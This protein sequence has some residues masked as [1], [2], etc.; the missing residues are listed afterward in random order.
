LQL[1][2][3]KAGALAGATALSLLGVAIGESGSAAASSSIDYSTCN[4][5]AACGGM[6]A[7]VKAA[8]AEGQLNTI[9]LP[10]AGWAN[11]GVIMQDFT[12]T[13]GIHITDAN[14]D[15]SSADE[16]AAIQANEGSRGPD[17][18]DVGLTHANGYEKY[19][20]PYKVA[21]WASIPAGLKNASGSWYA[22]YAGTV[23][24]ACNTKYVK[25]CPTSIKGL[26]NSAYKNM[27]GINND[28]NKAGAAFAA[29][30]S[31][32]VANGG[33]A[34]NIKPGVDFFKTLKSKGIFVPVVASISTLQNGT[35]PIMLWWDFNLL[36]SQPKFGGNF[37]TLKITYPSD[38]VYQGYY[39]QAIA[40]NSPNPAAARLWEEY[41]YSSVGQNL[42]LCGQVTPVELPLLKSKGTVNKTCLAELPALP[43]GAKATTATAAQQTAAAAVVL[44]YWASE[45]GDF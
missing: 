31:A 12:K 16:I 11:E 3:W 38:A 13:Y 5:L 21:T 9:T 42:F 6:T 37:S 1:S 25:V 23:A 43:K 17:V 26:N 15:G 41:L 34:N 40:V 36:P 39:N 22:D 4:S 27:V 10:L 20:A 7:L 2:T 14:P 18:V 28:P 35:T 44:K 19:F 8:K 24:I 29:V 33:S 32:A 30:F 45:V